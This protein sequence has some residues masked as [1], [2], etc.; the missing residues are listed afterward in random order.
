VFKVYHRQAGTTFA[1]KYVKPVAYEFLDNEIFIMTKINQMKH[2]SIVKCMGVFDSRS[3]EQKVAKIKGIAMEGFNFNEGMDEMK[4]HVIYQLIEGN[5]SGESL[6]QHFNLLDKTGR[7]MDKESF[8]FWAL[9]M[10]QTVQFLHDE[11]KVIHRDLHLGNWLMKSNGEIVLTDFGCAV[12]MDSSII[13]TG[14]NSCLG[15][16]N[17]SGTF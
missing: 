2:K 10:A 15:T 8:L 13:N 7:T 16:S 17:E 12:M 5:T 11:A 3:Q 1:A 14:M 9:S 6:A 4:V